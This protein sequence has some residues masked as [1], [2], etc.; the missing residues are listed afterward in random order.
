L[1]I[2]KYYGQRS[3]KKQPRAQK[4][5]KRQ[6]VIGGD[7]IAFRAPAAQEIKLQSYPPARE[8]VAAPVLY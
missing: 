1:P 8:F 7:P 6:E 3:E 2:G 5:E 4:A